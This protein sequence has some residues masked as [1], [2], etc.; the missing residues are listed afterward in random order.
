LSQ[1]QPKPARF[2]TK[3]A[4]IASH[5]AFQA[6]ERNTRG[7]P[8][9]PRAGGAPPYPRWEGLTT[10][11]YPPVSALG[12]WPRTDENP[13]KVG[14]PPPHPGSYVLLS[15]GADLSGIGSQLAFQAAESNIGQTPTRDPA[16]ALTFQV[17]QRGGFWAPKGAQKCRT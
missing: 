6:A 17:G 12:P 7:E 1:K 11:P 8:R 9:D 4:S 13:P 10:L 5:L 2:V 16:S 15:L 14:F 3:T